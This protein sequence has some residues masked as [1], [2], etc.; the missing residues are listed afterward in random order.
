MKTRPFEGMIQINH[1]N[2][3]REK[4]KK[5]SIPSNELDQEII[6]LIRKKDNEKNE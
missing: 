5:K 2:A 1:N 6:E 4:S 3:I